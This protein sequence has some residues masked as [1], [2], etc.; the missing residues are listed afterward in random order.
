MPSEEMS[1]L[2]N[3][4]RNEPIGIVEETLDFFF[5]EC[6]IDDAPTR[7]EIEQWAAILHQRGGKFMR[8]EKMCQAMLKEML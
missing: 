6:S 4:I 1:E 8:L 3:L 7:E 5:N 2:L